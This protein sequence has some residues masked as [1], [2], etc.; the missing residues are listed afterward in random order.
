[1]LQSILCHPASS[2]DSNSN[3]KEEQGKE[4]RKN[5]VISQKMLEISKKKISTEVIDG[6]I[7]SFNMSWFHSF[8]SILD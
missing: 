2:N 1:M 4:H 8:S 3:K 6:N 7:N 5:G